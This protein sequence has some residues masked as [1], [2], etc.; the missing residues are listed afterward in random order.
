MLDERIGLFS[1][2][3]ISDY[4]SSLAP[5]RLWVLIYCALGSNHL[6]IIEKVGKTHFTDSMLQIYCYR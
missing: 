4:R 3:N 5:S 2:V 1:T 6:E